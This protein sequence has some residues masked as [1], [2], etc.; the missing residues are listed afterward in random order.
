MKRRDRRCPHDDQQRKANLRLALI[1]ASVALVFFVGFVA[2][3]V[4]SR[5]ELSRM[6]GAFCGR[7]ARQPRCWASCGRGRWLMFGFGYALVPMYRAICDALGIN[8]LSCRARRDRRWF[9]G[10]AA[11]A[12]TRRSTARAPITSSST[13]MRAGPGTSSPRSA[14]CR[15]T[16]AS[17]PR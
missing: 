4:A 1:L 16:R 6:S 9:G 12:A 11:A 3:I 14:R 10:R 15:C 8:V 2:K 17:W 7:C 13:P 5:A